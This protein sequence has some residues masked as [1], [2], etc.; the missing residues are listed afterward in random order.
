MN[1]N[2]Q[3]VKQEIEAAKR[4]LFELLSAIAGFGHVPEVLKSY[5][6]ENEEAFRQ[7]RGGQEE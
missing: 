7:R 2:D 5:L 1:D 3:T 6:L 4:E